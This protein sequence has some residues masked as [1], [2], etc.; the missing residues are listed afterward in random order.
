[1]SGA[2]KVLCPALSGARVTKR[3]LLQRPS[4]QGGYFAGIARTL[5]E[6][7]CQSTIFRVIGILFQFSDGYGISRRLPC[8]LT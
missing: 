4:N 3:S 7:V 6:E 2:G 8:F 1:M 5:T